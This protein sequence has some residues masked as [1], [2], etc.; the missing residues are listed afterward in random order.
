MF[1]PIVFF[2]RD[3]DT[4]KCAKR[5]VSEVSNDM[6]VFQELLVSFW[7][8]FNVARR[9]VL[10]PHLP[11]L[12]AP[13]EKG[14]PYTYDILEEMFI[15]QKKKIDKCGAQIRKKYWFTERMFGQ[16][17]QF[18]PWYDQYHDDYKNFIKKWSQIDWNCN[19]YL[20]TPRDEELAEQ[21]RNIRG[22]CCLQH[23]ISPLRYDH[24][25]ELISADPKVRAFYR[26]FGSDSLLVGSY[27]I[28]PLYLL[29]R[30]AQAFV[31]CIPETEPKED[32]EVESF[33]SLKPLFF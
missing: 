23:G 7:K 14:V 22:R 12:V 6:K 17:W 31:P 13:N 30:L 15:E 21:S 10:H 4:A 1:S 24:D 18:G 27:T 9:L 25:E 33:I 28:M 11:S 32:E 16:S 29:A 2:N 20:G 19:Y 3:G 8:S 26:A 5:M